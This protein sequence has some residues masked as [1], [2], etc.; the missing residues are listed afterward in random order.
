QV[1]RTEFVAIDKVTCHRDR[2]GLRG[3][4]RPTQCVWNVAG[5][6]EN[7]RPPRLPRHRQ[8]ERLASR[9]VHVWPVR[10]RAAA[11]SPP[12]ALRRLDEVGVTRRRDWK[13]TRR[14]VEMP[15]RENWILVVRHE[16]SEDRAAPKDDFRMLIARPAFGANQIVSAVVLENVRR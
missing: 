11:Y 14:V 1:A 5:A 8:H 3:Q 4:I 12:L 2:R 6:L 15:L 13:R 7:H 9:A 16:R 10:T